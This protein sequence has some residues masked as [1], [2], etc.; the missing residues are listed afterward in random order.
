MALVEGGAV[1]EEPLLEK[2]QFQDELNGKVRFGQRFE[3]Q[4]KHVC[5]LTAPCVRTAGYLAMALLGSVI[6]LLAPV[7]PFVAS[8]ASERMAQLASPGYTSTMDWIEQELE[9]LIKGVPLYVIWPVC[10]VFLSAYVY[11]AYFLL[12]NVWIV[13]RCC[14]LK[15]TSVPQSPSGLRCGLVTRILISH[16]RRIF[17]LVLFLVITVLPVY[18][19]VL[20]RVPCLTGILHLHVICFPTLACWHVLL[21]DQY[22]VIMRLSDSQVVAATADKKELPRLFREAGI[23]GLYLPSRQY[24]A[25]TT[26]PDH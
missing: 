23:P 22:L 24:S 25:N 7:S 18:P 20:W 11:L 21:R 12:T 1:I 15:M 17:L 14:L 8:S 26:L 19:L 9:A 6:L 4:I 3:E 13:W 16:F 2:I 5:T 10:L